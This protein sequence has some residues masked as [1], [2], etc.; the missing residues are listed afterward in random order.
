[1]LYSIKMGGRDDL[2]IMPSPYKECLHYFDKHYRKWHVVGSDRRFYIVSVAKEYTL[3]DH[4]S[5]RP[6]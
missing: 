6:L 4:F 5:G 1:M 2:L 3:A